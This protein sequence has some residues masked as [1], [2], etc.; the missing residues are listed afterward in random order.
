MTIHCL[1]IS[2]TFVI[3][4]QLMKKEKPMHRIPEVLKEQGKSAYWLAREAEIGYNSIHSYVKNKTVPTLHN[5]F[6]IAKALKVS[7]K[8]LIAD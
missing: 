5:L 6:K 2:R 8:D 7:P 3:I 4:T 1:L